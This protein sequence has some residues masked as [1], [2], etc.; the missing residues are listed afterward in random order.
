MVNVLG[1]G[2]AVGDGGSYGM[3][4]NF[5]LKLGEQHRNAFIFAWKFALIEKTHKRKLTVVRNKHMHIYL[6]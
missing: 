3:F 2:G 4:P 6:F 1:G 5:L